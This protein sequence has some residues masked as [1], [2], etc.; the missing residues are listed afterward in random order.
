MQ[1]KDYYS[2]LG[3]PRS[4]SDREIKRAFRRLA[5]Q[6]HPD[7]NPGNHE[8]EERFKEINAAFE[9]ISDP[10]ARGKY[11][12][13]GDQWRYADQIDEMR[14]QRG[15]FGFSPGGMSG[16]F[17][18][19]LNEI[20]GQFFGGG[21]QRGSGHPFGAFGGGQRRRG[22]TQ[23]A[24]IE[25]AVDI[26]LEEAYEGTNRTVTVPGPG[27]TRRLEVNIPAGVDTGSRVRVAGAGSPGGAR[28]RP[29]GDLFLNVSVRLHPSFKRSGNDLIVE[30]GVPMLDALLGGEVQVPTLRGRSLALRVPPE[31]Q[32]GQGMR[33]SGQGMPRSGTAHSSPS[34]FGDLYV[35]IRVELPTRLSDRERELIEELRAARAPGVDEPEGTTE[36]TEDPEGS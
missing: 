27:R 11:D 24:N 6:Y 35:N 34:D 26:S 13:F 16:G 2:V 7:V 14:D 33:L 22:P 4:A 17:G 30:V 3:V 1:G 36:A 20:L 32:N 12:R 9:V 25:A 18:G 31:T 23:P 28:G 21:Q 29:A 5:R 19:N 15:G 10:E 8:A